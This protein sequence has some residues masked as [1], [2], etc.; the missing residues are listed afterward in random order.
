MT[1]AEGQDKNTGI[2]G[3]PRSHHPK[4]K[5]SEK[6]RPRRLEGLCSMLTNIIFRDLRADANGLPSDMSKQFKSL[7]DSHKVGFEGWGEGG[8]LGGSV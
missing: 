4:Y 8:K 5:P 3:I 6:E 7:A 1:G 2:T